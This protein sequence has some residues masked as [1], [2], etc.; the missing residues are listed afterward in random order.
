MGLPERQT[1]A[2]A[3]VVAAAA[4]GAVN[5]FFVTLKLKFSDALYKNLEKGS[6]FETRLN[7][8]GFVLTEQYW[9][10]P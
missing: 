5:W 6:K 9:T 7:C 3:A 2:A 8:T 1:A 4:A 10:Y